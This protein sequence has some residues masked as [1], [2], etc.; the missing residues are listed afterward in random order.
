MNDPRTRVAAG[1]LLLPCL[2]AAWLAPVGARPARAADPAGPA[3]TIEIRDFAF[4]PRTLTI[5]AGT[6]VTWRNHDP[7]PHTVRGDAEFL[8]SG[9]LDQDENYSVRFD[10]PGTYRY[11]CSIHPQM[12]ATIIVQ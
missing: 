12:S 5:A 3:A 4:T 2:L 6:T 9:A 10:K 1:W 8:R 7:E 11:G